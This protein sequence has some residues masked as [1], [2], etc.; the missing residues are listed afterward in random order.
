MPSRKGR[1][2]PLGLVGLVVV[3]LFVVVGVFAPLLAPHEPDVRSGLPFERPSRQHLLGT[4]DVGY[5]LLSEVLWGTRVSLLVGVSAA[6]VAVAVG[7]LVG[8]VAGQRRGTLDAV[9]MRGV[10]LSLALPFVPL[11]VVL[12]AYLGQGLRNEVLALSLLLWA[13]PARVVRSQVLSVRQRLY[14][15]AARSYGARPPYLL[16]RHLLPA[17]APLLV[18]EF[19]RAVTVAIL[20][21]ATL[22]FLGLGDPLQRSWGSIVYFATARGAFLTGAWV[23]WIVPPGLCVAVVAAGFAFLGVWVEE[24]VDA[25]LARRAAGTGFVLHPA[26]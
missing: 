3:A 2:R 25:R 18:A 10:D 7:G 15:T 5:D 22:G 11:L 23:W 4:D 14:V 9:L 26:A 12:A 20:L 6:L 16:R 1:T 8:L 24:R 17:V 13:Y 21:E 19:V